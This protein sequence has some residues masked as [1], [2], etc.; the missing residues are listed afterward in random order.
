MGHEDGRDGG[1]VGR[2]DGGTTLPR[3]LSSVPGAAR[4]RASRKGR[5]NKDTNTNTNENKDAN[6]NANKSMDDSENKSESRNDVERG[7]RATRR[8]S[9]QAGTERAGLRS[10]SP[11][12]EGPQGFQRTKNREPRTEH[13]AAKRWI[14][15]PK[16]LRANPRVMS[17]SIQASQSKRPNPRVQE[18]ASE[19]KSPGARTS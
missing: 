16:G 9:V 17:L 4:R 19:S 13:Q 12:T 15:T 8:P 3:L 7:S 1:M 5:A 6:A 2:W 11:G 10:S 14:F 18:F